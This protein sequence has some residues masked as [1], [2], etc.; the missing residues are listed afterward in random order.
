VRLATSETLASAFLIPHL[1]GLRLRHPGLSIELLTGNQQLDLARREADIA[2]RLGVAPKQPTLVVRRI[3][4]AGFALYAAPSYLA[5]HGRPRLRDGLRGHQIVC[6]GAELATAPIARWLAEHGHE[7]EIAVRTN[8]VP[9]VCAA[10]AAGLGLGVLPCFIG[11]RELERIG[12]AVLGITPI[13]TVVHEDLRRNARVRA[14]LGFLS[15][16]IGQERRALAGTS[17]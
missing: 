6:Y 2:V 13:W 4:A 12:S 11:D 8:S 15:D 5:R 1:G 10:V 16:L 17:S 9:S 14:V 3:G 7:A